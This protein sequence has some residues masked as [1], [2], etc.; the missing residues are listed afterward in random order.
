MASPLTPLWAIALAATATG[1]RGEVPVLPFPPGETQTI[2]IIQWDSNALPKVYQRSDQLPLTTEDIAKL[3]KAGFDAP[4]IVKMIEERRCACDA[5]ADGLVA[6]KQQ[7]VSPDVLVAVSTH[8]LRPNRELLLEVTLDFVGEGSEARENTLYFFID[9]GDVTRVLTVNLADLLGE[10]REHDSF[11]D[12]SDI[13][14][15][16]RVRRIQLPGELPLKTYGK[17]VVLVASSANPTLSHPSQL[18]EDERRRAQ[19]YSFEFPRSSLQNVCRLNAGYKRDAVLSYKWKF[20]G[21]RF[22][23]EWN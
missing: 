15:A 11:V 22:E 16:K 7:G 20:V 19:T 5:S 10:K 12:R 2:N 6:L 9:D 21:S 17:H 4:R 1:I 18:T 3:S 23:C 13:L 14:R 8:A